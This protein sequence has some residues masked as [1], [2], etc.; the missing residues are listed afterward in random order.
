[1]QWGELTRHRSAVMAGKHSVQAGKSQRAFGLTSD[2]A[3]LQIK[4]FDASSKNHRQ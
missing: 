2:L 4:R 1:M 3:A